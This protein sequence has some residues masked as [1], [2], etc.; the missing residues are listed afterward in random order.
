MM[1]SNRHATRKPGTFES[2]LG[3]SIQIN[4]TVKSK[5]SLRIDGSAEGSIES[6]AEVMVGETAVLNCNI[7]AQDV[8]IA[9]QVTGDIVCTGRLELLP[10]AKLK[11][12]VTV[13][14]LVISEGATFT[15]SSRMA[16]QGSDP[17]PLA[18]TQKN[19]QRERRA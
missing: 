9:G 7:T 8:T 13:G 2:V 3:K 10:T 14:S 11:G 16:D 4:G 5:G 1:F 15:G 12:D 17:A 6:D 19:T 18:G